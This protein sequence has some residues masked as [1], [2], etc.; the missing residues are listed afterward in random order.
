MKN[1]TK[2]DKGGRAKKC[3][4][5]GASTMLTSVA[6]SSRAAMAIGNSL[7]ESLSRVRFSLGPLL[8][9][10]EILSLAQ[11]RF[12]FSLVVTDLKT[13]LRPFGMALS[14]RQ[15]KYN[16]SSKAHQW[17]RAHQKSESFF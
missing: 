2:N 16:F 4:E 17:S 7:L 13:Q 5:W 10:C 3:W 11:V 1:Q 8:L 15:K 14:N 12:A 9:W 6:R